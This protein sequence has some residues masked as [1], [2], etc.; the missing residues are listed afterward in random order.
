MDDAHSRWNEQVRET[1]DARAPFWDDMSRENAASPDRAAH[2]DRMWDALGLQEGSRLLDAGCGTGQYAIAFA[3]RGARVTGVDIAPA[4]IERARA[5]GEA[6][7]VDVEW[8]VGDTARLAEPFAVYHAIHAQKSLHFS[9]D[10]AAT[11]CEFRRVLRPGGRLLVSTPGALSPIY[12]ESW[13]RFVDPASAD[14][15]NGILP[16]EVEDVLQALGW[17]VIGGWGDYGRSGSGRANDIS[18]EVAA[19]LPVRLQQAAAT[20][21]TTIAE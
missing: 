19:N 14:G 6:A 7:G 12:G 10:V 11:L 8:R 9:P 16:W 2:L 3:Q 4:M 5:N 21:W 13:V 20:N 15:M 1:W 17:R 18:E